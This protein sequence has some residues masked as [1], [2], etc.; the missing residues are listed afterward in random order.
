MTLGGELDKAFAIKGVQFRY[1]NVQDEEG[2]K[3][4]GGR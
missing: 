3:D 4:G 2:L 1:G